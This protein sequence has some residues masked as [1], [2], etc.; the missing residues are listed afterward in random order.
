VTGSV[1]GFGG[2]GYQSQQS[3]ALSSIEETPGA[4][5]SQGQDAQIKMLQS[6]DYQIKF[7]ASQMKQV[8]KG[9]SDATQNPIQQ[10]QQFISDIVVLIGGGQLAAGALDF[11]DLQYILPAIG[12]LFGFG[13]GP[14][15]ISLFEA[16][17]KL[18]LGYV[19]PNG[20][21]VDVINN[22]IQA[23]LGTLGIDK[24]FIKDVKALVTAVGDLFDGVENL[25]PSLNE[26]FGALGLTG[27]NLGPLGQLL[28]PIMDLFTGLDISSF[29]DMISFITNAIDPFIT[30]LTA[31]INWVDSLLAIFGFGGGSVVNSPLGDTSLPFG[32]L[33]SFLGNID[34]S[35]PLFTV[36]SAAETFIT[37]ILNPTGLL[38]SVESILS[39]VVDALAALLSPIPFVGSALQTFAN[40]LHSTQ[41]T[42]ATAQT[43]ATAATTTQSQQTIAKPGYLALDA[44]ADAVFPIANISGASPSTISVTSAASVIGFIDTP[45]NGRKSSVIW[46]GQD[47]A[48]L[49]HF[50]INVYE[51][52]TV[53]GL[54]TLLESS[55]DILL[56]VSNALAWNYYN[57]VAPIT[58]EVGKV[59]AVELV[60]TG[61]GTYK[62]AGLPTDWKP[63]NTASSYP[64]QLG[65]GRTTSL[66]SPPATFTPTYTGVTPWFGLGGFAFSGPTTTP[67]TASGTYAIPDWLKWGD[68]IDALVLGDGGGGQASTFGLT[69]D[70]G[71]AGA[72]TVKTLV[73]GVDIPTSTTT[74][75]VNVGGG[76]Y[77]GSGAGSVGGNGTGSS[78]SGVGV[79]TIT[80][81]GGAGGNIGGVAT[82]DSPGD[83]TLNG[84]TYP[85]G[86]TA[87]ASSPGNAP[88]GGG[89]GG[90]PFTDGQ[91]G[92]RGQVWLAAYQAGTTP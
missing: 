73:Y 59:Y 62:I 35:N 6:H 86:G 81:A 30:S 39:A 77:G 11:G 78:V 13:D 25:F 17:E 18:F 31:I 19:V 15:P 4:D 16:A 2:Q 7:L 63:A 53:T 45:D 10:V 65:S 51:L 8:Q 64:H 58:S 54:A 68:K 89:G 29:G 36:V 52:D 70:G 85:G 56:S 41:A 67:F 37:T 9:V 24:K 91:P 12:A 61:A 28:K 20:Q 83:Q 84:V 60:V 46:L 76:G 72:W 40:F 80:A 43:T 55:T 26:L 27:A 79:A 88:G 87:G 44:T 47:T 50:Y 92:A 23:W 48:S 69:G 82:G 1:P 22:I 74:L 21:F 90:G 57:L 32:N 42:A 14:F 71:A 49:T 34:F 75:T 33:L 3:R 5:L 38:A 66:T